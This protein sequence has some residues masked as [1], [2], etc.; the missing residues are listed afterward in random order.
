MKCKYVVTDCVNP[1]GNLAREQSLMKYA[2]RGTSILF[3]WRNENTI[4]IGRNQDIY[5]ECRAKEFLDAGG[6][7][8]RRRSGGGAVFHDLGNL[9]FSLICHRDDLDK[10]SY[11][12][13]IRKVLTEFGIDIAYNGRNDLIFQGRKFSGNAA[14]AEGETVCQHGT[15]LVCADVEKMAYFLTPDQGKLDRNHVH[16]V[17]SRVMNLSEVSSRISIESL[18]RSIIEVLRAETLEEKQDSEEIERLVQF[19][20]SLEWICRG[21]R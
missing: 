3:L 17:A 12:R 7:I 18:K 20:S 4:V 5:K 10:C 16:S 19:Y 21:A 15:I 11:Q 9:N 6:K 2:L 8:A 1:Y 14:Y 13:L